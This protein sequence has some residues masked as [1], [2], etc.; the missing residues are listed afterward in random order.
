MREKYESWRNTEIGGRKEGYVVFQLVKVIANV[1]T[2]LLRE[3]GC[4]SDVVNK[5]VYSSY[6]STIKCINI[7]NTEQ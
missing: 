6:L 2:T 4:R 7:K 5:I 1:Q 3:A